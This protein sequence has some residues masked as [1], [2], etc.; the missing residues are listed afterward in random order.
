M[1]K[2]NFKLVM[3]MLACAFIFLAQ[4]CKDDDPAPTPE[5]TT[6]PVLNKNFAYV[7]NGN[8]VTFTTTLSGTVW[9]NGNNNDYTVTDGQVVVNLPLKGTYSFTC[10][11]LVDGATVS[12]EAFDVVIAASDL[13]YLKVGVW[14][15]LTGGEAGYNKTWQLD[16]VEVVT[17]TIGDDGVSQSTSQFKSAFFHNPLDFYGDAEAGGSETNVWGPWGGTNIYGWGGTPEIGEI[18]FD[19]EQ[20]KVKLTLTDG[21]NPDGTAISDGAGGYKYGDNATAKNGEFE[22]TFTM[23]TGVRDENFCMFT[24][25]TTSL[26]DNMLSGKYSYLGSLSDST[27][28]IA[29]SDGLR[30]PMDKGRVG[31]QQF[32]NTDLQNV[33]IM[34]CSDSALIVR[35]KRS[36]EGFD[37]AGTHKTSTCWLLY[38]YTVKGYDYGVKESVTHPVKSITANDLVGTWKLADVACNWIGWSLKNELNTWADGAAMVSTFSSWGDTNTDAK[39]TASTKVTLT[40][41]ANN[42]T[43]HDVIYDGTQEVATDYTTTYTVTNGYIAFGADVKITGFTGRIQLSGINVYSVDV[44]GSTTGLWLGQNNENKEESSAVHIIKQ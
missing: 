20:K 11:T 24:D 13:S 6:T 33:M 32:T 41:T 25:G 16:L 19:G 35:V 44:D 36:Y 37:A 42:V 5:D 30:F 17:T 27:A 14:K 10:K 1:K 21:V 43:I 34:H 8:D 29:F 15:A 26:W 2:F 39:K 3:A 31:E 23:E 9:F 18:T 38:N 7:V 4:A 28:T 40:F 12:S 22:G